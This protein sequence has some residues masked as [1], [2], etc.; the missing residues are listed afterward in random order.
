MFFEKGTSH[1]AI[2]AGFEFIAILEFHHSNA[3]IIGVSHHTPTLVF[4]GGFL[5]AGFF[6][7]SFKFS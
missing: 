2:Q 1:C 7:F 6:F 3:G 4:L 5:E